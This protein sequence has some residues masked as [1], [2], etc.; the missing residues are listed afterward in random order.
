MSDDYTSE[1][2]ELLLN[3]NESTLYLKRVRIIA[4]EVFKTI[5]NLRYVEGVRYEIH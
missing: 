2:A 3:A 1:Y 5:N 4:Q